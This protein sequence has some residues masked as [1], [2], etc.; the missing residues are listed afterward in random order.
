VLEKAR[1]ENV[2][3]ETRRRGNVR[4]KVRMLLGLAR[5][6]LADDPASVNRRFR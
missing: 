1:F 5:T 3:E 4:R 6:V 2:V